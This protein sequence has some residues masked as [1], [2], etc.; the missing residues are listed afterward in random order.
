MLFIYWIF[1]QN[2]DIHKLNL[3]SVILQLPK[4]HKT[5]TTIPPSYGSWNAVVLYSH[6]FKSLDCVFASASDFV[7]F[8]NSGI[9]LTGSFLADHSLFFQGQTIPKNGF[10]WVCSSNI[11][12]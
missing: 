4:N 11:E 5:L 7:N 1:I 10:N 2:Q 3:K 9:A 6:K 8:E 12:V